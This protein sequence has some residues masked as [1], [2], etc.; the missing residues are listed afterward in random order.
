[1]IKK[2]TKKN[3]STKN[4]LLENNLMEDGNEANFDRTLRPKLLDDY[5]GQEKTVEQLKIFI[6]ATKQR[7]EPL[8]HVLFFGPPG[9]GKT[10]LANILAYEMEVNIKQTSGPVIE[11]AGDLASLL[12]NL[13]TNDILFI[14]EI[15]RLSPAIE[16]ILYP[17]LEDF[18]LDLMIGEGPGARSDLVYR[19]DWIFIQ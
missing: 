12:T 17:A 6:Q 19:V 4:P 1:M 9:I 11:K 3:N 5:I 13:E 7:K 2:D 18:R 15:H 8:D 16:E 14:D 10:T